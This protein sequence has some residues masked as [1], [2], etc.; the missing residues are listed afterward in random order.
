MKFVDAFSP[1]RDTVLRILMVIIVVIF[2]IISVDALLFDE[3]EFLHAD[4][5]GGQVGKD[6]RLTKQCKQGL[7]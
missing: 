4:V 1:L 3:A 6:E 2:R 5:E 7:I